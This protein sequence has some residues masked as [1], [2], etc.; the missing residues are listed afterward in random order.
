MEC[1][2][3]VAEVRQAAEE[4]AGAIGAAVSPHAL[5]VLLPLLWEAMDNKKLWQTKLA[6]VSLLRVLTRRA[7]S[8]VTAALPDIIPPLSE[9]MCDAKQQVQ[10]RD[11]IQSEG[12]SCEGSSVQLASACIFSALVFIIIFSPIFPFSPHFFFLPLILVLGR[13]FIQNKVE[14]HDL[15]KECDSRESL[16]AD[17]EE[18]GLVRLG[19]VGFTSAAFPSV[20]KERKNRL[21]GAAHFKDGF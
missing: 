2:V 18:A 1:R 9:R 4:A 7:S 19:V 20:R 8:Q 17:S 13:G 16:V 10:V 14:P 3:Q 15:K 5:P 11:L 12:C 6:A 21:G